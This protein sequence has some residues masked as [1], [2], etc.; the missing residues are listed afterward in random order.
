MEKK[1]IMDETKINKNTH[2]SDKTK[3]T[4]NEA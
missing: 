2:A 1:E 3:N 4:S